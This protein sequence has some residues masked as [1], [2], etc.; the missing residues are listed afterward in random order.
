MSEHGLLDACPANRQSECL[1][2]TVQRAIPAT[3]PIL[4]AGATPALT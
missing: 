4:R 2:P 3:F 1:T